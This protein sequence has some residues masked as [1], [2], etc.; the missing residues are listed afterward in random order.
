M[1]QTVNSV[2]SVDLSKAVADSS[3]LSSLVGTTQYEFNALTPTEQ[4]EEIYELT[5]KCR[6][7]QNLLDRAYEIAAENERALGGE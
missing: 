1:C 7:L 2:T 5:V 3:A 6:A 4:K